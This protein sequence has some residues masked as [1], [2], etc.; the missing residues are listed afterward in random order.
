MTKCIQVW[1]C[2]WS[3]DGTKIVSCSRDKTVRVWD[4]SLG[5]CIRTL[6]G[7][8]SAVSLLPTGAEYATF[9]QCLCSWLLN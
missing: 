4:A 7:Q 6:S 9:I 5:E 3:P 1:L 2:S 8:N